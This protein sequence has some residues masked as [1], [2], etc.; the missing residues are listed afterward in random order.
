[1]H[2]II[3]S[4]EN[5]ENVRNCIIWFLVFSLFLHFCCKSYLGFSI[6]CLWSPLKNCLLL[7]LLT[8]EKSL[9]EFFKTLYRLYH[10]R[11]SPWN[12]KNLHRVVKK[13]GG[14]LRLAW[15]HGCVHKAM[16]FIEDSSLF[17]MCKLFPTKQL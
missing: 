3:N 17:W 7:K 12:R 6:F 2:L 13:F 5:T 15:R 14:T 1:M 16:F 9:K 10:C 8:K 4:L 11:L